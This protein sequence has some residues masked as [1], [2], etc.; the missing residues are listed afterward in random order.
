MDTRGKDGSTHTTKSVRV[1]F[2]HRM[3]AYKQVTL[4]AL[5]SLHNGHWELEED[6]DG[7][8]RDLPSHRGDQHREHHEV[9]GAEAGVAEARDFVKKALSSNSR[10]TLGYA[11]E[12]AEA[13][14]S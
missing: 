6:G 9:L 13:R 8:L 7:V 14:R 4:P 11:K 3:I 10:A 1:C 2:P 5:M 12:Y